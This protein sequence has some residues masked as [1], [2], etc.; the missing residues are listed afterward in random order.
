V[1]TWKK[2][3]RLTYEVSGCLSFKTVAEKIFS[4]LQY[5]RPYQSLEYRTRVEFD[6]AAIQLP[7]VASI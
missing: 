7:A 5:E 2:Q 1:N 4:F 3:L 6:R